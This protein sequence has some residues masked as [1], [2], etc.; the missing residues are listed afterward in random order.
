MKNTLDYLSQFKDKG[1]I[2]IVRPKSI[3]ILEDICLKLNFDFVSEV[4]YIGKAEK[5]KTSDLFKRGKQEMGWSNFEGATF[6]RKIG[7][8]LDFDIKDK[9]NK[10][11]QEQTREFI[12]NNFTIECIEFTEN[13]QDVETKYIQDFRPCFNVKKKI[14][15]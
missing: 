9:K 12:C 6:V 1:G 10:N 14:K 13:I 8:F 15:D 11:L 7:R 3:K 2:Y 5:T 4:A